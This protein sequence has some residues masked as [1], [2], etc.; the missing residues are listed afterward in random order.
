MLDVN[1][2]EVLAMVSKPD[3][4]LGAFSGGITPKAWRKLLRDDLHPMSNRVPINV[5]E[6]C[7]PSSRRP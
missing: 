6:R 4:D 3:Y 5:G 1:T 7:F 2:L